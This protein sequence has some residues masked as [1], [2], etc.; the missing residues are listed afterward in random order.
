MI[1]T[2]PKS[3]TL[4]QGLGRFDA[5]LNVSVIT[6]ASLLSSAPEA[7]EP[8]EEEEPPVCWRSHPV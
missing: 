1:H 8:P 4:H 6:D 3:Q 5:V 7:E 2:D